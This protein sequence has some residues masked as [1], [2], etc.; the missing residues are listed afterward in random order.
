VVNRILE[1][2]PKF[3]LKKRLKP[4]KAI[5]SDSLSAFAPLIDGS[6]SQK[7]LFDYANIRKFGS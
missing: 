2:D 6:C 1:L 5:I 4:K 7:A 3:Y